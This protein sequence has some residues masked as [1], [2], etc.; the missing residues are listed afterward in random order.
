MDYYKKSIQ[1]IKEN[2]A[3]NGAYVASPSFSQYGFCWFR[4]SSFIAYA[5]DRAKEAESAERF[6]RWGLGVI[7]SQRD[8]IRK[9]LEKPEDSLSHK[10]LLPT[11]YRL[12]GKV[13][14]DDWPNGQSDGYGTFIW[15]FENHRKGQ[16]LENERELIELATAYLEKVWKVPCYDS[17]EESP[18]GIHTSTLLSIAAGLK[19]AEVLLGKETDWKEI[20]D[21]IRKN[22]TIDNRLVK[23]SLHPGV[24]SSL[25]WGCIPYGLFSTDDPLMKNTVREILNK[26]YFHGGIKR[27]ATD[28]YFGGGSWILLTANV[29]SFIMKSGDIKLANEIRDWMEKN[30]D[31]E[32]K[33]PEQVPEHFLDE[34]EYIPW[35]EKWGEIASPLLWSHANYIDFILDLNM[36]N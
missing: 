9:L 7:D 12:S 28:T 33:L 8:N 27:Y 2:Q 13:N 31:K 14:S 25:V 34:K 22:L 24:D 32:G 19:S 26:L 23:S 20:M 10:D 15:A 30:F 17:W 1:K 16:L 11:R 18:R 4:D 6:F 36:G 29:G 21:F 35:V 3:E 5:M